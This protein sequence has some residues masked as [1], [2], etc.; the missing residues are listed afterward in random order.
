VK[1]RPSRAAILAVAV[2]AVLV[3]SALLWLR[4][5]GPPAAGPIILISI[6]TLRA[7]RLPAYGYS[8][9]RTP[10]IDSLAADGVLF[11]RAYA[12][13]PQTLPSHASILTG[14]LPFEHGVRDN[15]GF[16]VKSSDR[17]LQHVV[18]EGGYATGGFVSAYVLRKETG[19]GAGFDLYDSDFPA[20]SPELSIGQ[21]QREGAVTIEHAVKWIDQI[22]SPKFFLFLHLYEPHVPYRPPARFASYAPYDGEVAYSDE[23]VGSFVDTLKARGLYDA[24][25]IVLLS[26]HGEGLGDHGELEHGLFIYD[27]SIRIPLIVKPPAPRAKGVRVRIPVQH[28]DVA[29]TLAEAAGVNPPAGRHGRSLWSVIRGADPSTVA[30][31]GIYSESL[32]PRYHFGW[33]ELQALTDSRYRFIKAPRPELYDLTDD[34]RETRNIAAD[35]QQA[36]GA[37]RAALDRLASSA[38]VEKPSAITAAEREQFQA[39]GYVGMQADVGADVKGE[40]LPDPKDKVGVL[41]K[42]RRAVTLAAARNF[43]GAIAGLRGILDED[44]EMADV[45]QQLGNLL[46]RVDRMEEALAAYKRFVALKPTQSSGLVAVAAALLKLRRL[47]EARAH[48]D[49]AVK[50]AAPHERLARASAHEMLAKIALARKDGETARREALLAQKEDPTLPMPLYVQALQLHTAGR[51]AEALPLFVEAAKQV[52]ARTLTIT[53][54]Y[55][56]LGDTLA[57]LGRNAE[58][59]AAFKEE[60]RQFPTNPRPYASLAMLYRSLGRDA[61]AEQAIRDMLTAAPTPESY[62]IASQLWTMFGEPQKAR[63]IRRQRP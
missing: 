33:S 55:F 63:E 23:L 35:R 48:A 16:A 28:I 12:H 18:K 3:A 8:K 26:D 29:P 37:M 31:A 5:S 57:R 17:M 46:T 36:S 44:P 24:A 11:E 59:E 6:D 39:L 25:T 9:I 15:V 1:L 62:S 40:T 22:A 4:R 41:E 30:E 10:A 38:G 50:V 51:Y 21:V 20:S 27:E 34:P 19:I 47:D 60:L 43:E 52:N 58:A 42:Y 53:E 2:I 45:W 14:L 61:E 49:L 7:D 13:A 56:Y 32:Y 54:L